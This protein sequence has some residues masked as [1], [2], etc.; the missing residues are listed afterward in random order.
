MEKKKKERDKK[1]GGERTRERENAFFCCSF[2]SRPFPCSPPPDALLFYP[3]FLFFQSARHHPRAREHQRP[4]RPVLRVR[5][6]RADPLDHLHPAADPPE[7]RVLAVEERRRGQRD[8]ELGPVGVGARVGHREHA[9]ARMVEGA[10]LDLVGKLAPEDRLAA[11]AGA[12][13]VAALDHKVADD[14]VEL[15]LCFFFVDEER[16]KERV[17]T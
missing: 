9:R 7:D 4:R 13:R 15:F 12:R 14:S 6:H 1:R 16:E 10:A 8:E 3:F 17:W 5:R 11:S 2:R